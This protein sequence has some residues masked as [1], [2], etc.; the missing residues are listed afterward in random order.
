MLLLCLAAGPSPSSSQEPPLF[1]DVS[2]L[3][4]HQH[5][6]ELFDDFERQ[7]L[8]QRRLSQLGPGI[9]W[10]D[11]GGDGRDALIIASGK[12]GPTALFEY[13][14]TDSFKRLDLPA[15]TQAATRDQTTILAFPDAGGTTALLVGSANYEDGLAVGACIRE[16]HL[17][18]GTI[19]DLIPAQTFSLGPIALGDMDGDGDLDLF[20]GGRV[21]PGRYPEPA[22]SLIYE[23]RSGHFVLDEA[24]SALLKNVGLVSGAVWTDL[25]GDGYPELVLACEWGPVKIF[26][27]IKGR[28]REATQQ[29]GLDK[30]IGWWN[31]VTAGDFDGDGRMDLAV[32]NWGLNSK[33]HVR[34]GHGPRIYAGAWGSS[35]EIEPLEASFDTE[36][37]KWLPQR[38]LNSVSKAMPWMRGNFATH[39]AYAEPGV[40]A[41]LGERLK[42]A[43]VLEV[44]W[45]ETT[46][47]LNRGHYFET[48]SLPANV[49][50]SPAFGVN[51]ADFDGDGNED[52]F[53][54]QNFFALPPQMARNDAGRGLLLTGNGKGDFRAMDG[55]LSGIKVYG[56]QRGSAVGDYDGDG[57]PDLAVTQNGAETK[58]FHNVSAKPGLRVRLKGPPGNPNGVGAIIRV[59]FGQHWGPAREI[60]AGS[61]YWSQDS[62][63]QVMGT[64]ETATKVQVLWPGGRKSETTVPKDAHQVEIGQP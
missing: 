4:A 22:S 28:L 61:G 17:R 23:N 44:S 54:S 5:H 41:I 9:T 36:L 57:R 59:A 7:G 53:L 8:L 30:K 34:D 33:Y 2:P 45:L 48:G 27:N 62:T 20:V 38:D 47:F 13:T 40:E 25:D 15:L 43:L 63:V 31:G 18:N 55:S 24:N 46:V 19:E 51:V 50:F 35:G 29:W 11:I 21:V 37:N 3:L 10:A 12:G 26:Q 64:P 52:I 6:E 42:E 58:L 1:K 49:Q 14:G 32:S 39:R 16:Y 60:H 56:E